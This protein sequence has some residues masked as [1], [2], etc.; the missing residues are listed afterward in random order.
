MKIYTAPLEGITGHVFRTAL[1]HHFGGADKYFIPFIRP[2]QNGN[3]S[4]R[5]KQDIMPENNL[6]MY[7]VPQILTNKAEDFLQTAEKQPK[8]VYL[9][10][11][12]GQE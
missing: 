3:F 10:R 6:N 9:C 4:T 8:A 2:N 5:E 12:K 1:Y 11:L 7:A